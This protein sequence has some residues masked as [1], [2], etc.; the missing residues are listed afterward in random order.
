MG[1]V[2]LKKKKNTEVEMADE[3][4]SVTYYGVHIVEVRDGKIT[5]RNGGH[6]THSTKN[7]LNQAAMELHLGFVVF[8]KDFTWYVDYG[9][10]TYLFVDGMQLDCKRQMVCGQ[11][12][13]PGNWDN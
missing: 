9:N 8:A 5:L 2:P 1:Y 6:W 3:V 12:P 4:T 13:V 10:A 11:T 7:R